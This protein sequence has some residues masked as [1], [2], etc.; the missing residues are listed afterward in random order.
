M[1]KTYV[2][3]HEISLAGI[4]T[5]TTNAEEAGPN[6]RLPA[7]WDR[8][9]REQSNIAAAAG[10]NESAMTALYALYTDYESDASG[11]YTVIIGHEREK[12]EHTGDEV[13]SVYGTQSTELADLELRH[14]VIP[15][16]E[17][18]VFETRRG[19]VYT[20]VG[21][22]WGQI[23]SYFQNSEEKRSFTGDYELYDLQDF[24][25]ENAVVSIY[26]AVQ[27]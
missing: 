27:S 6:G 7:L 9:F 24:D 25:P 10:K 18:I 1:P 8:Y 2:Q 14:A 12:R 20:V 13:Q 5:R 23:W 11:A 26:I 22:A 3:Q 15:A 16:S 4:G 19:P 21:E 17:Y